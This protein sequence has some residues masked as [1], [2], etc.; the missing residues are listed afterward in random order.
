[1]SY[2]LT[3]VFPL[4]RL[5]KPVPSNA[6]GKWKLIMNK[7]S[8]FV[9]S[10]ETYWRLTKHRRKLR[11]SRGNMEVTLQICGTSTRGLIPLVTGQAHYRSN[12]T[13]TYTYLPAYF[14]LYLAHSQNCNRRLLA[15]WCMFACLSV[16]LC[17]RLSMCPSVCV[18]VCLCVCLSVYLSVRMEQLGSQS[19]D[20]HEIWYLSICRKSVEEI[21]ISLKS[22]KDSGYSAPIRMYIYDTILLNSSSNERYLRKNL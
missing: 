22:D 12:L 21:Q 19:M 15:S 3:T 10:S 7:D 4:Q 6:S 1:M 13:L 17:V 2:S 14:G 5:H 18:S 16:C 8:S 11:K 20:F 9:W